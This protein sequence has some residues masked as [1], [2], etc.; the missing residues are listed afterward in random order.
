L[1]TTSSGR[2]APTRRAIPRAGKAPTISALWGGFVT[3][4]AL[5]WGGLKQSALAEA[6][7][8]VSSL[9]PGVPGSYSLDAVYP[10]GS[11]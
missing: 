11:E 3:T 6:K 5:D 8:S 7:A 1:Q 4:W 2:E 9:W 10:T